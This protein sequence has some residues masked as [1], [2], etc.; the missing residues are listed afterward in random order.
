MGLDDFGN[1]EV[2]E[3]DSLEFM[4]HIPKLKGAIDIHGSGEFCRIMLN[5]DMGAYG[6]NVFELI[7]LAKTKNFLVTMKPMDEIITEQVTF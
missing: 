3:N 7:K 2:E 5:I 1:D 4:A 6:D